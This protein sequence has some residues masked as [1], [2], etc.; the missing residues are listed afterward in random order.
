MALNVY[1]TGNKADNVSRQEVLSW[2]ND[3]LEGTY[4][5]IEDMCTGAAYCQLLDILYPGV[6]NLKRVLFSTKLEHEYIRNF[7]LV[8]NAFTNLGINKDIPVERLVKGRFQDNYE[9]LVWFKKFFDANDD[10]RIYNA[11]EARFGLSLGS[12]NSRSS[13]DSFVREIKS[14]NRR[15]RQGRNSEHSQTSRIIPHFESP[16]RHP[17]PVES[18]IDSMPTSANMVN[19][20]N[21]VGQSHV[22]TASSGSVRLPI[23]ASSTRSNS[24]IKPPSAAISDGLSGLIRSRK[25]SSKFGHVS[26]STREQRQRKEMEDLVMIGLRLEELYL[27]VKS[28]EQERDFYYGKLLNIESWCSQQENSGPLETLKAILYSEVW[29]QP[30]EGKDE[31]VVTEDVQDGR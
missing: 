1:D 29:F 7:K 2:V 24:L 5:R 31:S 25:D 10:N 6:V 8:Q 21:K 20:H 18:E 26:C 15:S 3:K 9:F 27:T 22:S 23:S 30:S 12:D 13:I 19:V 17:K 28:M 4:K 11:V 14:Q 16:K